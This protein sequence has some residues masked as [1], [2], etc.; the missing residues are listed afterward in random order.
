MVK[1][2]KN[3][4]GDIM[5]KK[6]RKIKNLHAEN[7]ELTWDISKWFAKRATVIP[8]WSTKWATLLSES[9]AKQATEI[10]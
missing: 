7:L 8:K 1:F 4:E 3:H 5:L 9:L 6:T 10:S 2:E